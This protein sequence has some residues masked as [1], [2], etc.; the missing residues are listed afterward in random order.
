[1]AQTVND[2]FNAGEY[3]ILAQPVKSSGPSEGKGGVWNNLRWTVTLTDVPGRATAS[4]V[5][6]GVPR[7]IRP[8]HVE[9][10]KPSYV[11][12]SMTVNALIKTKLAEVSPLEWWED[13]TRVGGKRAK[14][15]ARFRDEGDA[16]KAA[17]LLNGSTLPFH[18]K[19]KL[20]VQAIFSARFKV[21][22]RVYHAVE[23]QVVEQSK[24]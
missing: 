4:D 20:T 18:E 7:S 9:M 15:K 19:G 23:E 8:E 21:L 10:G 14:G 3:N 12:D 17:T 2:K 22:D 16:V 1:M 13:A 11:C 6:R 5:V 24:S